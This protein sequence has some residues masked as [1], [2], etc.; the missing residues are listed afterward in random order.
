MLINYLI[1]QYRIQN[2]AAHGSDDASYQDIESDGS[3]II[4]IRITV[5]GIIKPSNSHSKLTRRN[6]K[7]ITERS[8][9]TKRRTII[10]DAILLAKLTKNIFKEVNFTNLKTPGGYI[11]KSKPQGICLQLSQTSRGDYAF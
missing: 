8:A 2:Q 11:A 10:K 4:L 9:R 6:Y 5:V 1:S 7:I 3:R